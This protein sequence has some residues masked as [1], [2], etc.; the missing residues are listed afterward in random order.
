M[1]II[2]AKKAREI[3]RKQWPQLKH[4]WIFER[5][6]ILLSDDDIAGILENIEV[7]KKQYKSD[8]FEC[9]EFA[10]VTHSD[11]VLQ[12]LGL[13]LPYNRAFGE[14]AMIHPT[15]GIHNQNIFI[16]EDEEIRL[17]EPQ[18]N[19]IILPKGEIVFYVRM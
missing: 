16:T 15:I 1:K 9:E 19:K 11:V 17:F 8:V 2:T 5:K 3:L 6:I 10:L 7:H 4:I 14:A 12:T 18:A 13:G